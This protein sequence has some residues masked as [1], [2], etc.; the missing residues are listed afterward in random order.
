MKYKSIIPVLAATFAITGVS[1]ADAG[2]RNKPKRNNNHHS[3]QMQQ[4]SNTAVGVGAGT[5]TAGRRGAEAG[6]IVAG[7]ASTSDRCGRAAQTATTFGTGATYTDRRTASGAGSTG[8]TA[9]GSGSVSAGSDVDLWASTT[10]D[11]SDSTV[12]AGSSAA[13]DEPTRRPRNC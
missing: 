10:R 12:V 4:R 5:A 1:M 9:S 13:A 6:A 2:D 3:Q 11:G 8:G 7:G